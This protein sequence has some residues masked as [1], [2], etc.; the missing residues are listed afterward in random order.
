MSNSPPTER[1]E[2]A[3]R[4]A[5]LEKQVAADPAPADGANVAARGGRLLPA[6]GG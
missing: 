6:P 1:E 5:A 4:V 3:A 2:L